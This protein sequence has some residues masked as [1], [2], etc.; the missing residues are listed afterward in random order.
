MVQLGLT[1]TA[2]E[3]QSAIAL[4][5]K[6]GSEAEPVM[7]GVVVS[8]KK[9]GSTI[10][11]S[12]VTDEKGQYNFPAA[13][14]EPG[15]YIISTRAAG[16]DLDGPKAVDLTAGEVATSD[17]RLKPTRNLSAQLTDA[18]WLMSMPG[19]EEQKTFLLT[20]NSCHT[21]ERIVKSTHDAA[22]FAQVFERMGRYYPGS[23]PRKPQ[24]HCGAR[25]RWARPRDGSPASI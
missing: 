25:P 20:C 12:V 19:T 15:H 16:Y 18:E 9:A 10:T 6:V 13:R 14:V 17:L 4:T 24:R 3:A 22:E 23:T 2:A 21:I 11:I 5:G 1:L 8:A 7:E